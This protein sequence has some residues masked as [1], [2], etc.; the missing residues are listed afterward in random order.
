MTKDTIRLMA[1][2]NAYATKGMN[3][4]LA[5]VPSE[6]WEKNFGGFFG[7]IKDLCDHI[8]SGDFTWLKRLAGLRAFAC[9]KDALLTKEQ[10][11][12]TKP[13][14]TIPE[15]LAKRAEL[16]TLIAAFAAE[17]TDEDLAASLTFKNWAGEMQSKNFG[18]LWLHLFNHDTHHR[19]MI[20]VYLDMAGIK[21]DFSNLIRVI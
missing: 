6:L 20:A 14:A 2:Y 4:V 7:S 3:E 16:D 19:G 10:P 18:G 1:S 12:D 9:A 15:Y 17:V 8:Y 21:N 11:K 5:K 13:F